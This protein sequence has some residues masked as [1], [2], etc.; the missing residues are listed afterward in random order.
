MVN[1][2]DDDGDDDDNN[3]NNLSPFLPPGLPPLSFY[4]YFPDSSTISDVDSH[5]ENENDWR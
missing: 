5:I 4:P 1:N 2:D 3:D